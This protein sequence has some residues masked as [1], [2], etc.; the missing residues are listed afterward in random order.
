MQPSTFRLQASAAIAPPFAGSVAASLPM[1]T[2]AP[3][4]CPEV[5]E[6]VKSVGL[7]RLDKLSQPHAL[8][9]AVVRRDSTLGWLEATCR[10][11]WLQTRRASH[12]VQP[13]S[14]LRL[15]C[16]CPAATTA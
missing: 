12:P 8:L 15:G 4:A 1:A 6:C 11:S 16:S 3:A 10:A 7:Y 5:T 14:K 13:Y 2:A 9:A